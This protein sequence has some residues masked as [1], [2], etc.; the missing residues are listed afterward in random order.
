[1]SRGVFECLHGIFDYLT[2]RRK[3]VVMNGHSS[4]YGTIE[5]RVPQGSVVGPLLFIIF[6]DDIKEGLGSKVSLFADDST[7]CSIWFHIYTTITKMSW[8]EISS[9]LILGP[10][11]GL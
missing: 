1:M 10:N 7:V 9:I 11:S 8:T 4:E 2:D 5:A 6:I 3:C